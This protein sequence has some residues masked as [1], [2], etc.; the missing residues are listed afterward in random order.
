MSRVTT[1]AIAC[2]ALLLA[3]G[4]GGGH[5]C[6]TARDCDAAQR[7]VAG[8]CAAPSGPGALGEACGDC[9]AGLACSSPA[10]G[11][12]GGACSRACGA[13]CGPSAGCADLRGTTADAR[14]C[15]PLCA[16][17][18]DCRKDQVCCGA[19]GDVCLP[20]AL[21]GP[22][23]ST[24][25][26]APPSLVS[27]GTV[28]AAQPPAGSCG[29]PIQP[30]AAPAAQVQAFGVH[31]VGDAVS[32]EVPAGT[33][34]FS[35]F[36]QATPAAS[37]ARIV[38]RDGSSDDNSAVPRDL[39][40]PDGAVIF[41]DL[42]QPADP[43]AA[44]LFYPGGSPGIG[45][46][47]LP[48]T[49]AS[50]SRDSDAGG[51]PTGAWKLTVGDFAYECT[52]AGNCADGGS[53]AGQYDVTVVTR[54]GA[55]SPQGAGALD[56]AFYIVGASP[57][58]AAS[59]ARSP[60]AR[61][62]VQ[63][64]GDIYQQAG[65]C[66]RTATFYDVPAWA[67][68]AYGTSIDA[69]RTGPCDA[70]DQMFLLSQP[71]N[72]LHFFL[73]QSIT[74]SKNGGGQVVGIDGTIPG[75]ASVSGTIH[76]GAAVSIADLGSAS[77]QACGGGIDVAFC[78]ADRVAYI[79]AHEGGHYLGLFHLTESDG[80]AFDPL[81]DTPTCRCDRCAPAS[82]Q[83]R[84]GLGS[85]PPLVGAADC[86][87]AQQ[88][89]A[90]GQYLMFWQLDPQVSQAQISPQQAQLMRLSPLVQGAGP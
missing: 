3:W 28:V 8:A 30:S 60:Q 67:R 83:A 45:S 89:C 62:M 85:D 22:P 58:S 10:Q 43:T 29:R 25:A 4:C 41:D 27:G 77:A 54:P 6:K 57:F 34:S 73:V 47:T 14:L 21:C 87:S 20:A 33:G 61:R 76:S 86:A 39:T 42:Q 59:A 15:A 79:A 68:A 81:V 75:P 71:G 26:C 19:Q 38:L 56:L 64:L 50:L 36:E 44:Q 17:S 49:S 48:N 65:L 84:C 40:G 69:D 82:S 80:Q 2:A 37:T 9:A 12:A 5:P 11:F 53:S 16:S 72:A 52:L 35:V 74:S 55:P 66:L 31:R 13:G 32:F 51:L 24:V 90:G 1:R 78:A 18:R 7:C 23:V 63:T 46:L 70:L 88:P